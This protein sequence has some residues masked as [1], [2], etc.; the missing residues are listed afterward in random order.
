MGKTDRWDDAID[1]Y[2]DVAK[3]LIAAFGAVGA[4]IAGTAPLAGIGD[5]GS[6]RIGFVVVGG[7]TALL[8]VAVVFAA[9]IAVLVPRTVYRHELRARRH[10]LVSRT[11]VGL[12]GIENLLAEN[13]D[14]LLPPGIGTIE[15][16][17]QAITNLRLAATTVATEAAR[18]G[19]EDPARAEYERAAR[20]MFAAQTSHEQALKD[21]LRVARYECARTR[22]NQA[23][24]IVLAGGVAVAVGLALTLYGIASKAVGV[25]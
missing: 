16:L 9:T 23:V 14:D 10:G 22:F 5:V 1:C 4:V 20:A 24:L 15:E 19:S 13:P 6:D 25:P 12:G 18:L 21:L 17:G 2:R 7:A 11:F 3:W 8:G